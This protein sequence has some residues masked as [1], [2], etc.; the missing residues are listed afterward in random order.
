MTCWFAG[1]CDAELPADR[2]AVGAG[3]RAGVDMIGLLRNSDTST[4][5]VGEK[6]EV[7]RRSKESSGE[8]VVG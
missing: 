7:G 6:G 2:M 5:C 3:G 8:A 1:A 4:P